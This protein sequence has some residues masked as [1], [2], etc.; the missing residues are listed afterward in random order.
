MP[1]LSFTIRVGKIQIDSQALDD[2]KQQ[3]ASVFQSALNTVLGNKLAAT[4]GGT[5][6]FNQSN[7][8]GGSGGGTGGGGGNTGG[9]GGNTGGG[10]G[11]TGGGGGNTG[12][13]VTIPDPTSATDIGAVDDKKWSFEDMTTGLKNLGAKG[14]KVLTKDTSDLDDDAKSKTDMQERISAGFKSASTG[15]MNL[16]Q[17][18]VGFVSDIYSYM[19]RSSPFLQSIENLFNLAM[20]LFFMPLGNKLAEEL[21][22]AAM[23]MIE[24]VI[25][26]WDKFEGKTFGEM[27]AIAI[28][29]GVSLVATLLEN[30]GETLLDQ[31]GL[32]GAIGNVLTSLGDFIKNDGATVLNAIVNFVSLILDNFKFFAAAAVAFF[33]AH[34]ASQIA[35]M[36][37]IA[38]SNSA[39]GWVGGG[40]AVAAPLAAGIGTYIVLDQKADGGYIPAADGGTHVIVGEGGEGEYIVPESRLSQFVAEHSAFHT[41]GSSMSGYDSGGLTTLSPSQ[42]LAGAGRGTY[43]DN[44]TYNFTFTGLG[45]YDLERRVKDIVSDQVSTS[46]IMGGF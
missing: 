29:E 24:A 36:Y 2:L 17:Q 28:E 16:L 19:K 12:G 5:S 14:L 10:G 31:G 13:V 33:T 37:T 22:P 1:D 42:P 20:Q 39:L 6:A 40:L 9:G 15:L 43:T 30:V 46:R 35:M 34:L 45:M 38:S 26:I 18:S 3:L 11:N 4:L 8:G 25:D 44:R 27:M 23:E 21:L 32:V 41:L 7:T